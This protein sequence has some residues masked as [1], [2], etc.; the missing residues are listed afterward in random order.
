MSDHSQ[1]SPKDAARAALTDYIRARIS[2]TVR[3]ELGVCLGA[4]L[5]EL[6][7]AVLADRLRRAWVVETDEDLDFAAV[8]AEVDG[9]CLSATREVAARVLRSFL[10]R[11][12]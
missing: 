6:D 5:E 4:E 11:G 7:V 10:T 9:Y 12:R 1:P 8:L 2:L 3:Q